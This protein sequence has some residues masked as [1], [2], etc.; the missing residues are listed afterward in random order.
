[1]LHVNIHRMLSL[2]SPKNLWLDYVANNPLF[3]LSDSCLGDVPQLL[4]E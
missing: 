4:G 3:H 1:M 2:Y